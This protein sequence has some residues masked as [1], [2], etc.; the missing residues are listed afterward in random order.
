M[1]KF[2]G[3]ALVLVMVCSVAFAM[4]IPE[5]VSEVIGTTYAYLG[6][7]SF[8]EALIDTETPSNSVILVC[9]D[10]GWFLEYKDNNDGIYLWYKE[11][12]I[13]EDAANLGAVIAAMFDCGY[14]EDCFVSYNSNAIMLSTTEVDSE[15]AYTNVDDF[16]NA[17][18]SM[19]LEGLT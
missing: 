2:V 3:V 9:Y 12:P 5:Q 19:L 1:K 17:Y 13:L 16:L 15:S 4:S 18:A 10:D 6:T 8:V 7:T 11:A 14:T